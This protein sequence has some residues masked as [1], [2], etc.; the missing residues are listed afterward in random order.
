MHDNAKY[1]GVVQVPQQPDAVASFH[2]EPTTEV[3][4]DR[5]KPLL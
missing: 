3:A 5:H 1:A 2:F 4:H